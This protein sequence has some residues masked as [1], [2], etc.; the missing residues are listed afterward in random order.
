MVEVLDEGARQGTLLGRVWNPAAAGPS[1]VTLRGDDLVD[2]TSRAAPTVRD[3]CEMEDP[4]GYVASAEGVPIGRLDAV[5]AARS[6]D[7]DAVHFLAPC[8]L[9]PVKGPAETEKAG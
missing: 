5:A 3:I 2:I 9:Q 8:D 6:G 1:V 7:A 4:A